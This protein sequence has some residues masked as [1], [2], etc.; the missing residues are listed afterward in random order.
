MSRKGVDEG[1]TPT[2]DSMEEGAEPRSTPRCA[3]YHAYEPSAWWTMRWLAS[4]IRSDDHRL[5]HD[6]SCLHCLQS[7]QFALGGRRVI[8]ERLV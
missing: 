8:P 3:A 5:T 1:D 6:L 4:G 7:R 2:T